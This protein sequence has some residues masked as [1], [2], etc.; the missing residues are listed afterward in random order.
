MFYINQPGSWWAMTC[1]THDVLPVM[2][3]QVLE[4]KGLAIDEGD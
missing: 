2:V 4:K 1:I 3:R